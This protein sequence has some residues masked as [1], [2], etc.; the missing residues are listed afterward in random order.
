MQIAFERVM[1]GVL[2]RPQPNA[3]KSAE[4]LFQWNAK[5]HEAAGDCEKA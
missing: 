3:D 2:A 4:D 1:K 5:E